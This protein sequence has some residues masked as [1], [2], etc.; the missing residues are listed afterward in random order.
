MDALL[1]RLIN[2]TRTVLRR[3]ELAVGLLL[4]ALMVVAVRSR[5]E[6]RE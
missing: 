5:E 4:A 1:Q 3:P 2:G 6:T